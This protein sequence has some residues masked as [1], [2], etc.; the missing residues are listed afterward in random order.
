MKPVF[1]TGNA[2]K[3]KQM[4]KMLGIPFDHQKIDL[5]EI[6]SKDPAEVIEHK[7][8]QAYEIIKRPVFVDDFS[9]WFD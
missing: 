7:V 1:I 3:A 4:E 5:D 6:Q 9:F 2:H 8:R